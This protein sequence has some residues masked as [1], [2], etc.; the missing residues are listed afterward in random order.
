[1][2]PVG[3]VAGNLTDLRNGLLTLHKTLLDSERDVYERDVQRIETPGRLLA[4]VLHDPWF[5]WLH[6]LSLLIVAI[7]EV[8]AAE[9]APTVEVSDRLI[10]EARS[11]LV[12]DEEGDGFRGRY[13]QVLQR[14][15]GAVIAHGRMMKVLAELRRE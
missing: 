6:E 2:P 13:F 7:D 14:D 12:P 8:L 9:Q 5:H 3:S 4:L 1:M 11:L 15:P 10:R